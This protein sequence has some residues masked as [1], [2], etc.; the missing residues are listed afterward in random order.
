MQWFGLNLKTMIRIHPSTYSKRGTNISALEHDRKTLKIE[1]KLWKNF[2]NCYKMSAIIQL[3][4]RL[5]RESAPNSKVCFTAAKKKTCPYPCI[6]Y[7]GTIPITYLL[8]QIMVWL[9]TS[10]FTYC[11]LRILLPAYLGIY[12][13]YSLPNLPELL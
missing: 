7:L 1:K 6:Q 11:N 9:V 8:G 13:L 2:Q 4:K 10:L 5:M 12:F 3:I